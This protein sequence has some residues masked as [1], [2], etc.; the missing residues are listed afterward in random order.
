MDV[1]SIKA[2]GAAMGG[3]L[4]RAPLRGGHGHS[5]RALLE[6]VC[7]PASSVGFT[8]EPL[9]YGSII[10]V[11]D[12]DNTGKSLLFGLIYFMFLQFFI[13]L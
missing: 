1:C 2:L 5:R 7:R 13:G 4:P 6:L 10:P 11:Y 12:Y 9:C 3:G 8:S